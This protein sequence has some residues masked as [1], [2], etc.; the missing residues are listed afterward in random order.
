MAKKIAQKINKKASVALSQKEWDKKINASFSENA[1]KMMKK[2]Y[3]SKR[4]DGTQETPA[5]MFHRIAHG[6]ADI[7]RTK[8][9]KTP[10]QAAKLEHDFFEVMANKEHTPAGRTLTNVGNGTPII[11][12]C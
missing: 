11:A 5:E 9:G 3:L 12:N 2:R 6:L 1:M 10:A 8:Y 4:E 7:E